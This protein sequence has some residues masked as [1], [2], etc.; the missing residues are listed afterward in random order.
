MLGVCPSES[1][2]RKRHGQFL[3]TFEVLPRRRKVLMPAVPFA[4]LVDHL[5]Q[6]RLWRRLFTSGLADTKLVSI[7]LHGRAGE[8]VSLPWRVSGGWAGEVIWNWGDV[9]SHSCSQSLAQG[10][11]SGITGTATMRLVLS[12]SEIYKRDSRLK[13]CCQSPDAENVF[14]ATQKGKILFIWLRFFLFGQARHR[15]TKMF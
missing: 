8:K 3:A 14:S 13:I 10:I 5:I 1:V 9:C 6:R 7:D 11:I 12:L 15:Q 4:Q 2:S